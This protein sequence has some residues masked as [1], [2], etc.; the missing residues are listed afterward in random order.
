MGDFATRLAERAMGRIPVVRPLVPSVFAP[1]LDEYLLEPGNDAPPPEYED[2][3]PHRQPG[4]TPAGPQTPTLAPGTSK[5]PRN[6]LSTSLPP[7]GAPPSD[8]PRDTPADTP[9][10]TPD[11]PRSR[12][13]APPKLDPAS[14]HEASDE[15]AKTRDAIEHRPPETDTEPE[16]EDRRN[17]ADPVRVPSKPDSG[18]SRPGRLVPGES[19]QVPSPTTTIADVKN[20]S[21][22][23]RFGTIQR[24][25]SV[26]SVRGAY[27]T[28]AEPVLRDSPPELSA[29]EDGVKPGTP[30]TPKALVESERVHVAT[31]AP[32]P[33]A[34]PRAMENAPR[35]RTA[36]TLPTPARS[37]P[38]GAAPAL[39]PRV[40]RHQR[41]ERREDG[42]GEPRVFAAEPKA[43]TIKV[44]I[45]RIE[46]RAVT[47]PA[48]PPRR[49]APAQP[50]PPLSLDDYLEQR[51]GG[52]T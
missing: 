30:G 36:S 32:S 26:P 48:P 37:T 8:V 49:E 29:T 22:G 6:R 20:L 35:S 50:S 15:G 23:P 42:P 17:L 45:G 3:I 21:T 7:P 9:T 25:E 10:G 33:E 14:G 44:A 28:P 5:T 31:P 27:E 1:E 51:N 16:P 11:L 41:E 34:S 47:P 24:V 18:P 4:E 12:K 40:V 46:V 13:P 38:T 43:P 19:P 2:Q 52:R 39:V